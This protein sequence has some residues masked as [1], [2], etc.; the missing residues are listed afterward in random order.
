[1]K[2]TDLIFRRIDKLDDK[3][4]D[5]IVHLEEISYPAD[6]S[7]SKDQLLLRKRVASQFFYAALC[8]EEN[9]TNFC[10]I[11]GFI[12]G[13][14]CK[15]AN[16]FTEEMMSR[17]EPGGSV[18]CIHSLVVSP[19]LRRRGIATKILNRYLAKIAA[20]VSEVKTVLLI[21]KPKLI[22]L[23]TSIGFKDNGKSKITHGSEKWHELSLTLRQTNTSW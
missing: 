19:Q 11:A 8:Y 22:P 6:E 16:E 17:H 18:L 10:R 21:S 14:C 9:N 13:T 7:A 2:E 4:F 3:L 1:M 12:N 15:N 23:Y 5:S 20:K